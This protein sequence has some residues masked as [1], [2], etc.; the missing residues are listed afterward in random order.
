MRNRLRYATRWRCC[1]L[2]SGGVACLL[3]TAFGALPAQDAGYVSDVRRGGDLHS[4]PDQGGSKPGSG[5][6]VIRRAGNAVS[7]MD[8]GRTRVA[9]GDTLFARGRTDVRLQMESAR[10][11]RGAIFLAPA[12]LRCSRLI[13]DAIGVAE[14]GRGAGYRL[15]TDGAT[16]QSPLLFRVDS[17][18]AYI[19]WD[20]APRRRL[21]VVAGAHRLQV[22]GTSL[23][24]VVLP[25]GR[26]LVFVPQGTVLA[27]ATSL[28]N[29][30]MY[31]LRAGQAPRLWTQSAADVSSSVSRDVT[32]HTEVV[33]RPVRAR[34]FYR[35]PAVI[36]VAAVG[37][38]VAAWQLINRDEGY[39]PPR[40][41]LVALR[42][43]M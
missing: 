36:G 29:S 9:V 33:F 35:H 14:G 2:V 8:G 10:Y 34:A 25:D 15:L 5:D 24:V 37:V 13:T 18:A 16:A 1:G 4:S 3:L 42:L 22:D 19:Q 17:G 20:N 31:E 26:A 23:G 40:Q 38:G 41:G 28:L 32:Y 21:I 7:A 6:F 30:R 11:G 43:P 12:L 39:R 27:G